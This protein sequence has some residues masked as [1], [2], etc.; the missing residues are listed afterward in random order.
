MTAAIP[1]T[2]KAALAVLTCGADLTQREGQ[3]L[4]GISFAD[5]PLSEKQDR[6]LRALLQRHGL[7]D[8]MEAAHEPA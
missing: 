6:W 8:L 5:R 2:R 1:N 7:S 3:F 4:G